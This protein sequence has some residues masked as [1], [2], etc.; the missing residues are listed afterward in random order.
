MKSTS[1][2]PIYMKVYNRLKKPDLKWFLSLWKLSSHRKRTG[3][4][5]SGQPHYDP[6]SSENAF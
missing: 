1:N 5:L 3:A 2:A 6:Q 4:D